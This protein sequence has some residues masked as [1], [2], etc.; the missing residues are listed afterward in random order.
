VNYTEALA[1]LDGHIN[2]ELLRVSRSELPSL[3]RMCE[4]VELLGNPQRLAPAIHI[5]GTNGKG[6]TSR[7]VTALVA[8]HNLSVGTYTSPHLERVNDRIS[9]NG[10]ATTDDEFASAI[11]S[12]AQVLSLVPLKP[13]YF[14]ILVAAAF[15]WFEEVAVDVAV[16]EVGLGGRWDAT[17][18]VDGEVAVITNVSLDHIDYIGPTRKDI[19]K[20]K[21]GI[22]KESSMVVLG[23]RDPELRAIF[24]A[25]PSERMYVIDEDFVLTANEVAVGGRLLSLQTPYGSYEDIFLPLHGRHQGQN[26]LTAIVATEVFFGRALDAEVLQDGLANVTNPGRFEVLGH[27]PLVLVDG[28]HNPAGARA[29]AET[30]REDFA[31]GGDLILVVGTNTGHDASDILESLDATSA[32]V[33][34]ATAADWQRAIPA[35]QV[36]AAA[37]GL[38]CSV[39]TVPSVS[40]AVALALSLAGVDDTVLVCGSLY[41]V[42]E[43]RTVL[44]KDRD[45]SSS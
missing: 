13:S 20:E 14:E 30:L 17:N 36:A 25:R 26:A 12:V 4:L 33:V 22:I 11:S 6:S 31:V 10:V 41:V 21:S 2:F 18:V 43:A 8:E 5:T 35:E 32:R 37:E 29:A 15:S 28:A 1:F 19:A 7:I 40:E 44:L 42:G 45:G 39:E 34:V 3:E 23:E 27:S 9:R 16:V 38:G 24:A